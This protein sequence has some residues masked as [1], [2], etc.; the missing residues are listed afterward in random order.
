MTY[1]SWLILQKYAILLT[2]FVCN[3][4]LVSLDRSEHDSFL[5]NEWIKS[6]YMNL[7]KDKINLLVAAQKHE[8]I[9]TKIGEAK[10]WEFN[11]QKLSGVQIDVNLL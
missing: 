8:S 9:G 7:N 2:F 3:K 5:A 10:I 11:K 1:S 4:D 6:N